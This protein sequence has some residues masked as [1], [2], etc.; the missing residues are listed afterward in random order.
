MIFLLLWERYNFDIF[1]I[2]MLSQYLVVR[3]SIRPVSSMR[4]WFES[5]RHTW[6]ESHNLPSLELLFLRQW[7]IVSVCF[8]LLRPVCRRQNI[9]F[10]LCRM[11]RLT[12]SV[13]LPNKYLEIHDIV[14]EISCNMD[15]K[16]TGKLNPIS[17]FILPYVKTVESF[18]QELKRSFTIFC[19]S[20]KQRK[21]PVIWK[22]WEFYR[23]YF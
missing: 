10:Y 22:T 12:D 5:M 17:I 7:E 3:R 15:S 4:R 2:M 9:E 1:S 18:T 11:P 6:I 20:E 14:Y 16:L 8:L 23:N 21:L 19:F 13:G